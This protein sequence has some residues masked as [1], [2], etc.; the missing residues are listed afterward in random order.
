MNRSNWLKQPRR[1]AE[2]KYDTLLVT[3]LWGEVRIV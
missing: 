3:A 2:E 1:E